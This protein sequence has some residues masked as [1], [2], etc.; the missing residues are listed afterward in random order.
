[1]ETPG[2]PFHLDVVPA[3]P[4]PLSRLDDLARDLRYSWDLPTRSLFARLNPALWEA[5]GH[6]PR[7]FLNQVDESTLNSVTDDPVY[8]TDFARVLNGYDAYLART[9]RH[10]N[11]CSLKEGDF[12][13]YFCFEFGFH[14]SLPIYSGG[15]GILAGDHCKAASDTCMPFVGVGL[16]YRQGYFTQ[17]IDN[18]GNQHAEY[19][20]ADFSELPVECAIGSD[21]REVVPR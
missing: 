4:A 1:M 8:M 5:C 17:K 18:E 7:A 3:V 20:D 13:G 19:Q 9:S 10:A 11:G 12:V 21:G 14:E 16:L 2:T 15:L 6:S